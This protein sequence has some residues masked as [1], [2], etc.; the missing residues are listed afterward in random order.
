MLIYFYFGYVFLSSARWYFH[1][2]KHTHAKST[3]REESEMREKWKSNVAWVVYRHCTEWILVAEGF[4][5]HLYY[6]TI[7][8]VCA[9][10]LRS[11]SV[12]ALYFCGA[13]AATAAAATTA[14][15]AVII[16]ITIYGFAGTRWS[17][18]EWNLELF[19]FIHFSIR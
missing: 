17:V 12:D 4:L 7:I 1:Y 13:T 15:I 18:R 9:H 5:L 19:F 3:R 16:Y 6:I 11:F 8:I 14:A 10:S 2:N